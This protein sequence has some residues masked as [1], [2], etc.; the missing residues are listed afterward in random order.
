MVC[1]I[2]LQFNLPSL[3]WVKS[4]LPGLQFVIKIECVLE[5][6]VT[7]QIHRYSYSILNLQNQVLSIGMYRVLAM[8]YLFD[9]CFNL[10]EEKGTHLLD[11]LSAKNIN[12]ELQ[13]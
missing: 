3:N 4:D 10:L 5:I 9:E 2:Y 6:H 1:I 8:Y 13:I 7:T 11:L 12:T